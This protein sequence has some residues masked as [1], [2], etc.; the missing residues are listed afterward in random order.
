MNLTDMSSLLRAGAAAIIATTGLALATAPAADAGSY[1]ALG[2]NYYGAR[3]NDGWSTSS[4]SGGRGYL[5]AGM[6][7]SIMTGTWNLGGGR[8]SFFAPEHTTF[9]FTAPSGTSITEAT[10]T[11]H[12]TGL[13]GGDWNLLISDSSHNIFTQVPAG[14][15][16]VAVTRGAG[17]T[18]LTARLQC[19][20]PAACEANS[21]A[22]FSVENT[23]IQ[24]A[25]DHAPE[26]GAPTGALTAARLTG[27]APVTF[28]AT[29][30]GSG[31][32]YAH[33]YDNGTDHATLIDAN[34]NACLDVSGGNHMYSRRVPCL[35]AATA[36]A[37]LD[38]TTLND[39][40]HT[41][42]VTLEDA[43]GNTSTVLGPETRLIANHPPVNTGLPRIDKTEASFDSYA[44]PRVGQPVTFSSAG[45][46]SGPN[47]T[48]DHAWFRCSASSEHCDQIPG[49]TELTYVPTAADVG[50]TLRLGSTASNVAGT[51]TA[52]SLPSGEVIAPK[53]AGDVIDKPVNGSNGANGANGANG[54]NGAT[55]PV[56]LPALPSHTNITNNN[57]TATTHNLIGRVVGQDPGVACPGDRATLRFEH[58]AAGSLHLRYG[59]PSAAQLE[60][61][62]ATTGKPV[63][64]A[65]LEIATKTG[66]QPTVASDVT[67]D[68]TGH[69]TIRLA[70]GASRGITVGYRMYSDDVIARA[71][72]T[73]KVL[74]D[75]RISIKANHKHL[76]N[77]QAVTLRGGLS[78]GAVPKRGVTLSVQWKDGKRWRPFAQ[79]K[80]N[81]NGKYAYAYRFTRTNRTVAYRL[82]VVIAGGQIDYPY[83]AV[84]SKAVRVTVGR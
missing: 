73:L 83:V 4:D 18:T 23:A 24:L 27:A 74:V 25:D 43:A 11:E 30:I 60:L 1:Y 32:R 57:E 76:H 58:V 46:W 5:T 66:T 69:A 14:N 41:I 12:V 78:G 61:T 10:W 40:N 80:T 20:G 84:A 17:G 71:V 29:D 44:A 81:K 15:H 39:G 31:V 16:D 26:P 79:I 21:N 59:R 9:S 50:Y 62:C 45:S 68:G 49:S 13:V 63:A 38:T 65:K 7:T 33:I 52:Y 36:N 51:V 34:N 47:L 70:K 35:L 37:T 55:S 8:M 77:G 19:G 82:R 72:A 6:D 56:T 3:S 67:T 48:L 2:F 54:S 42:K 53:S 28:R 22:R 75:G 64:D